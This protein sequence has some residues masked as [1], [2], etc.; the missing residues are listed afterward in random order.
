VTQGRQLDPGKSSTAGRE[1]GGGSESK[2]RRRARRGEGH[3]ADG[4][5]LLFPS[6]ASLHS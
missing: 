1:A 2:D 5:Q 4:A 6:V 3:G